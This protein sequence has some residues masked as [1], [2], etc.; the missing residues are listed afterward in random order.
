MLKAV[1]ATF[2]SANMNALTS[3][4]LE[5]ASYAQREPESLAIKLVK[6]PSASDWRARLLD[7]AAD[8]VMVMWSGDDAIGRNPGAAW[9]T[10]PDVPLAPEAV[11]QRF[12]SLPF[13]VAVL[14]IVEDFWLEAE[15][16]APAIGA[17]HALLGWGMSFKGAGHE[18][19]IV[20]RR[21][22][23]HGPFRRLQGPSDTTFVQFCD[24]TA[25]GPTSLAQ[26]KPAHAWIVAGFLR[27]KHH[28]KHDITGVYTKQDGLLRIVVNGRTVSAQ[29]ILDACAARR[30]RKNDPEKPISNIAYIFV[31]EGEARAHLEALWLRGLECRVADG[32]GEQRL[33]DDFT[34]SISKPAWVE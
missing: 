20:S 27:P 10:F 17:D 15:Y 5:G 7:P 34:P 32:R 9:C 1:S 11:L 24:V 18:N 22:L 30:D 3:A 25:D 28:Y 6:Q 8:G 12:A 23:E 31:D 26:A 4:L 33:D 29:E 2:S 21:W 14:T 19:S 13:E 16:F